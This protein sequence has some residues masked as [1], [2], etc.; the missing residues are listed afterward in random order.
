MKNETEEERMQRFLD[1]LQRADRRF[2]GAILIGVA[3]L[4]VLLT[5]VA[6]FF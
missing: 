2:W 1:D 6:L 5:F 3:G 4:A